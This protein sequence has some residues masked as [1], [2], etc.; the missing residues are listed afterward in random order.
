[1]AFS[2]TE[3]AINAPFIEELRHCAHSSCKVHTDAFQSG[4]ADAHL[5]SILTRSPSE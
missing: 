2:H 5:Q 3:R 1:M 4:G